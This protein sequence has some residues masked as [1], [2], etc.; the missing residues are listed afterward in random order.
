MPCQVVRTTKASG[1]ELRGMGLYFVEE[2]ASLA[3]KDHEAA[4]GKAEIVTLLEN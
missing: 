1:V 3:R 4:R 2:I